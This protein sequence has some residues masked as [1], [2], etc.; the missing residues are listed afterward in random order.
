MHHQ[1]L[2][3]ANWKMKLALGESVLL[4]RKIAKI[5]EKYTLA[6]VVV[7][8]S[9]TELSA[10]S[11]SIKNTRVRLGAQNCF[12][13]DAGAYTGE[14]SGKVLKEYGTQYVLVGH[15]E[16]RAL[17]GETDEMINKKI[18]YLLSIGLTPV[19]CIGETFEERQ[20]GQ[21]D[22][23]LL[24]K[25]EKALR[26]VSLNALGSLVIAYEPVWVIG[27]GQA[28]DPHEAEQTNRVIKHALYELFPESIVEQKI[29]TLYGGSVDPENVNSFMT[30]STIDGV[31]VG[32]AS[33]D[34]S[35]FGSLV[36]A[37]LHS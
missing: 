35:V 27:S 26:G 22:T 6:E 24:R 2:L 8:P 10:V 36:A 21:K 17:V 28:V 1:P 18:R 23:V 11:E 31:L 25:V 9:F 5:A 34:A 16:R 4:A 3:I 14:I 15:S 19:L 30:Q 33:L 12:W 37:A 20:H 32:T 13:E 7:C 29:R